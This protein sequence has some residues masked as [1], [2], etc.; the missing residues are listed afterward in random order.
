V[1]RFVFAR[2]A[3]ILRSEHAAV[4]FLRAGGVRPGVIPDLILRELD[5]IVV[6]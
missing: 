5:D 2:L 4:D 1:L 3:E 6:F